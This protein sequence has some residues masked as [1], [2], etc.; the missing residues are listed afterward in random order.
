M[1][2]FNWR[3]R[4]DPLHRYDPV[5]QRY[6]K[7]ISLVRPLNNRQY[8]ILKK[9]MDKIHDGYQELEKIKVDDEIIESMFETH[10]GELMA[11]EEK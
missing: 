8:T 3:K 2:I 4:K 10:P 9:G 5:F 6:Q 1:S 11:E 7:V